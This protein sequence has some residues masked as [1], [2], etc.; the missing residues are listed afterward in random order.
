MNISVNVIAKGRNQ[1]FHGGVRRV[2]DT[3]VEIANGEKRITVGTFRHSSW[4]GKYDAREDA[5]AFADKLADVLGENTQ[6]AFE[7]ASPPPKDE[8]LLYAQATKKTT[9]ED[10]LEAMA[11]MVYEQWVDKKGYMPWTAGGN[12]LK[13][14]E[15]RLI[16][17]QLFGIYVRTMQHRAE[18]LSQLRELCGYVENGTSDTVSISQDDATKDW[19]LRIGGVIKKAWWYDAD[20]TGVINKAA[21]DISAEDSA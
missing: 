8:G 6:S 12:S 7:Q 5:V 21:G 19:T 3:E 10:V 14:S 15:A 20:F 2:V 9:S 1:V 18:A 16:V 11:K 17:E 4:L 13:Q